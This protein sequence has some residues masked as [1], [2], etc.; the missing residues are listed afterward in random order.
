M[1]GCCGTFL[2]LLVLFFFITDWLPPQGKELMVSEFHL[3]LPPKGFS[4]SDSVIKIPWKDS[5][6]SGCGQLW[7]SSWTK[8]LIT[9]WQHLPVGIGERT[10]PQRREGAWAGSV[11]QVSVLV[12]E[13]GCLPGCL[14]VLSVGVRGASLKATCCVLCGL[15]NN[16]WCSW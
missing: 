6:W 11:R 7:L 4:V 5:D 10:A 16:T 15:E 2:S 13:L 3:L 1:H 9:R 14:W 8:Q 12:T